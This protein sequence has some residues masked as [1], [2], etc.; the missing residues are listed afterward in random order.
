MN[1]EEKIIGDELKD[2]LQTQKNTIGKADENN[3][4]VKSLRAATSSPRLVM[5][6]TEV[7][8]VSATARS[9]SMQLKKILNGRKNSS[10]LNNQKYNNLLETFKNNPS[11][12]FTSLIDLAFRSAN[13][14]LTDGLQGFEVTRM[15]NFINKLGSCPLVTLAHSDRI[16][17]ERKGKDWN[18]TVNQIVN[19]YVGVSDEDKTKIRNSLINLTKVAISHKKA[20]QSENLFTQGSLIV[21]NDYIY[22]WLLTSNVTVVA[23]KQKKGTVVQETLDINRY[24]FRFSIA[25][26]NKY[27]AEIVAKEHINSMD[28][29]L[30]DNNTPAG[31]SEVLLTCFM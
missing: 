19:Y 28:D 2:W 6:V 22:L 18:T 7:G 24:Q 26:W 25:N 15:L 1:E 16:H 11:S 21:N 13:I 3:C 31:S 12:G 27:Y 8:P 5:N 9:R 14:N 4:Q 20:E 29:W 23:H 17:Y 30:N 10:N